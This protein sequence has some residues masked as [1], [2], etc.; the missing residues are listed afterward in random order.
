VDKHKRSKHTI[1]SLLEELKEKFPRFEQ[2][3][4]FEIVKSV[5]P[6]S[7]IPKN[8]RNISFDGKVF[9][10]PLAVSRRDKAVFIK[11]N[12]NM[13]SFFKNLSRG[14]F[15]Q[16]VETD[17]KSAKCVN[18]SLKEDVKLKYYNDNDSSIKLTFEDVANGT[19][20]P[21]KRKVDKYIGG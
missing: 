18:L 13:T 10:K 3:Q 8:K 14:D 11:E 17:G 7:S 1:N 9:T 16:V 20:R 5:Y 2:N 6:D 19:V 15:I 21:F 12:N 4:I